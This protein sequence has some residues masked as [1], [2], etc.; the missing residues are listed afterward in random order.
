MEKWF[1]IGCN[2]CYNGKYLQERWNIRS[3]AFV[4]ILVIM[5]STYRTFKITFVSGL[6]VI[7]VIMESTY[8]LRSPPLQQ[9]L[10]VILVIMESTYRACED[11]LIWVRV[12]ILVIMESTY[13]IKIKNYDNN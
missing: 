2:P 11:E 6:V 7:L 12:V 8:R 13:R 1:T 5:E 3:I 4:V 9:Y 10:V